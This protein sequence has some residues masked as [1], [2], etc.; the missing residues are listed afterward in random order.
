MKRMQKFVAKIK[1]IFTISLVL[2]GCLFVFRY[3]LNES[4]LYED[5]VEIIGQF[6]FD[7]AEELVVFSFPDFE[8]YEG[9]E[10]ESFGLAWILGFL[11]TTF[12]GIVAIIVV[13]SYFLLNLELIWMIVMKIW[14]L[15]RPKM[16]TH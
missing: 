7:S 10:R 16:S 8:V 9:E 11:S 5:H 13:A 3:V 15:L 14:K 6:D 1:I 2:F 12:F 4:V